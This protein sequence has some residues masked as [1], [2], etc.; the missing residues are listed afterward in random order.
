MEQQ[1]TT[2]RP[3]RRPHR[4]RPSSA[5]ET[6]TTGAAANPRSTSGQ[7]SAR[8]NASAPEQAQSEREQ[9]TPPGN[10]AAVDLGNG[11]VEWHA[12]GQVVYVRDA[13]KHPPMA[14]FVVAFIVGF[15]CVAAVGWQ[16][17]T[18]FTAFINLIVDGAI[19]HRLSALA[20]DAARNPV[21]VICLLIAV[22]FQAPLLFFAF[23]V[24]KRFAQERHK[25]LSMSAKIGLV[26]TVFGEIV[27]GNLLLSIWAGIALVADTIG[28]VG[29]L[30]SYTDSSV[31]LFF[32]AVGLY[33]L[34]TVGL[35]ECLQILWDGMV[36]NEW[37]KH[38][39]AANAWV[40]AKLEEKQQQKKGQASL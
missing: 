32:Y 27:A 11:T 16:A 24:D 20:Q 17:F 38:V 29:F 35:S 3:T 36:S 33:G 40:A 26:W 23:K 22:S 2:T 30:S 5:S 34:S 1:Q 31:V 8:S 10:G 18:T 6:T 21:G 39:R 19:W 28:D 4:P 13:T 14:S 9:Q 37:L 12:F 25:V 15:F 7:S